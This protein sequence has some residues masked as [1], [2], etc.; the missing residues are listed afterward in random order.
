[1]GYKI[2]GIPKGRKNPITV[3]RDTMT[4]AKIH[5]AAA[6][7]YGGRNVKITKI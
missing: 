6:R 2:T 1:M 3:Y 5:A 4:Q 7:K